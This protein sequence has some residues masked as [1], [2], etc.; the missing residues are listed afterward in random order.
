MTCYVDFENVILPL[1]KDDTKPIEKKRV[2]IESWKSR[3]DKYKSES[4]ITVET[5]K[6][7]TLDLETVFVDYDLFTKD[8]IV[9][10]KD[11]L[12]NVRA[13]IARLKTILKNI[14]ISMVGMAT[15]M[16]FGAIILMVGLATGGLALW[17][18]GALAVGSLA[19]HKDLLRNEDEESRLQ[20]SLND[21]IASREQPGKVV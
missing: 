6:N 10:I 18:G 17:I 15:G 16:A 13:E 5:F 12:V 7:L 2:V 14:E 21:L 11:D 3:W 4:D 8:K 19:K 1:V 20:G 9:K